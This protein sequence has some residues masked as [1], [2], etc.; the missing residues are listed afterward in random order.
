MADRATVARQGAGSS[1]APDTFMAAIDEGKRIGVRWSQKITRHVKRLG[2]LDW[3]E[4]AAL[5]QAFEHAE[6]LEEVGQLVDQAQ[7]GQVTVPEL[8]D[9]LDRLTED[10]GQA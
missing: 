8:L 4:S 2:W 5:K 1:P 6:R 3:E 9:E 10:T 7:Q